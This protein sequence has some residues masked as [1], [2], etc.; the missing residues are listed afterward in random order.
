MRKNKRT[1]HPFYMKRV[2]TIRKHNRTVNKIARK[3]RAKNR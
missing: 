1:T 3:S 2:R